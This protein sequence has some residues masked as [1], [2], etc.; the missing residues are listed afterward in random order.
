LWSDHR[1]DAMR[2]PACCEA[3]ASADLDSLRALPRRLGWYGAHP[4]GRHAPS[5]AL[6]A[7]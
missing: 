1:A 3:P 7:P 5:T 6:R 2:R 4:Y